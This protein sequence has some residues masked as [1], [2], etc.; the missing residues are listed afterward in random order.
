MVGEKENLNIMVAD[1]YQEEYEKFTPDLMKILIRNQIL[2]SCFKF[3]ILKKW[4]CHNV[5][6][7]EK[8]WEMLLSIQY[9][10]LDDVKMDEIHGEVKKWDI[11]DDDMEAFKKVLETAKKG[12]DQDSLMKAELDKTKK[13]QRHEHFLMNRIVWIQGDPEF[14]LE[15]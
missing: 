6:E 13:L 11:S 7:Q 9:K 5:E 15:M 8:T 14:L 4:G 1:P 12:R 3:C 10:D 2:G